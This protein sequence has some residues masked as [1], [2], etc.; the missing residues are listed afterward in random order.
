M[1]N[2]SQRTDRQR[3]DGQPD[4]QPQNTMP[5]SPTVSGKGIKT[6]KILKTETKTSRPW[7]AILS[8]HLS[9]GVNFHGISI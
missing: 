2:R 1:R 8:W 4:R 6:N 7:A 5:S 3:M 9:F